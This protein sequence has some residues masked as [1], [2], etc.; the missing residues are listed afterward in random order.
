MYRGTLKQ[1]EFENFN[2]PFGG[3][4]NSN[5]RW[6]KL[7]RM[8]PWDEIE[9]VYTS[10]LADTGM[11]APAKSARIALGALIIKEHYCKSDE[12]T[13]LEIQENPYLQYF[14]GYPE[15]SDEKPF[16][17]SMFTHCRVRF[18]LKG[19]QKV[20]YIIGGRIKKDMKQPPQSKEEKDDDDEPP[21]NSG[22]LILDATC[23]P[24]DITFPT[25]LK[26][27]NEARVKSESIID[28]LHTPLKGHEKKPRTWRKNARRDFLRAAKAKRLSHKKRRKAIRKQLGYL[29]RNLRSIE[30]LSQKIPLVCLTRQQYKTLLVI[31]EVYRQQK[32]MF[33][34]HLRRIDN[35]IVSIHQPHVRPIKR[36]KA[37]RDTEFGAKISVSLA[38][39]VTFVDHLGWDNFNEGG[40]LIAQT[41]AYRQRFGHWP[42]SIHADKIYRSRDNLKFCKEK[43]IRLSGPRLGRPPKESLENRMIAREDERDRVSIEGKFGQGKRRF[44]LGRIMSK[45]PDTSACSIVMSFL[46]MNLMKW[47]KVIFYALFIWL[48]DMAEGGMN[49]FVGLKKNFAAAFTC[50]LAM[51]CA[52]A[53]PR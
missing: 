51:P 25:D 38:D 13:V 7:A 20:N 9:E 24:A 39:G 29:G 48:T 26:L 1:M 49:H 45:G 34:N 37:G 42:E 47:L 14:L 35:R 30:D 21:K 23:A 2:L 12:E 16:D 50:Q 52:A 43:G 40:D 4:L 10:R 44:N 8:I 46:V 32:L 41:E 15:Y 31:H 6:V 19:T 53:V 5:N 33:D 3:K 11:G 28:D 17:P 18:G 22:K 36:G 27:L